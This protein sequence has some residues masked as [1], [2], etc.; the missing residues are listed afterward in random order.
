MTGSRYTS[1]ADR[2][3]AGIAA[4]MALTIYVFT[5]APTVTLESS[6]QL[7]VAADHLGVARTPGYPVWTLLAKGFIVL[8]PF[9][10][11]HGHPNPAWAVNLM[12]AVF[13]A[14]ACGLLAL[15]VSRESRN[16]FPDSTGMRHPAS[17]AGIA[18]AFL[19]SVSPAFWSQAVIA[20]THT[21][22]C[23][24]FLLLLALS[25]RWMA[26]H[27]RKSPYGLAFLAGFGLAVSHLLILFLPLVLLAAAFV[28]LK[29]FARMSAAVFLFCAFL[30][31]EFTFG[32]VRDGVS[33][34]ALA[35]AILA[36]T[37]TLALLLALFRPSRPIA[38]LLLLLLAGL[39]PYAYLPLAS[40]NNPPMNMGQPHT[41]EGFW[42]VIQRGQF[43]AIA[44]L[45]PFST[46]LIFVRDLAWYFRLAISQFT[47]P[48]AA[49]A[50][51]P[52]L[53]LPGLSRRVLSTLLLI[54]AAFFCFAILVLIGLD[55]Q[56]DVQNTWVARIVFIPSLALVVLLAGLGLAILLHILASKSRLTRGS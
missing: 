19:F 18:A 2:R 35:V 11:Y 40:A 23:F 44:P 13:G 27:D 38:G 28:S 30:F 37:L 34:G 3:T 22:T 42:H 9:A 24:Y 53:G 7:V 33:N 54:L 20:E 14:L 6:G 16:L 32:P 21:L 43:E 10:K 36:A 50:L 15:L 41:W 4:L 47:A 55:P 48:L 12:S 8:F 31:M 29:D 25:L 26:L 45:N 52:I 49:L 39:I 46:P 56:M 5:L 51:I 17:I 1:A